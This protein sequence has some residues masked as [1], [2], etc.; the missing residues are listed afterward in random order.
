MIGQRKWPVHARF[1][2]TSAKTISWRSCDLAVK[3][4]QSTK[5]CSVSSLHVILILKNDWLGGKA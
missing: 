3:L 1:R 2:M 5:M 4:Q